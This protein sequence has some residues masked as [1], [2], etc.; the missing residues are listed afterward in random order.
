MNDKARKEANDDPNY[1]N[2]DMVNDTL[3]A[4]DE[5]TVSTE[6]AAQTIRETVGED[7]KLGE[8]FQPYH[9]G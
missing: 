3:K 7:N 4:W 5:G 9:K 2:G 1:T 8:Y 6:E